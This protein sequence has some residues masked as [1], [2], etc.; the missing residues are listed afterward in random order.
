MYNYACLSLTRFI[1]NALILIVWILRKWNA[2]TIK[3]N[4]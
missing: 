4:F 1:A 3:E 2:Q